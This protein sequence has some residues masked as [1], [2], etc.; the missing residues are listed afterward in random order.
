MVENKISSLL[1]E[2]FRSNQSVEVLVFF[3]KRLDAESISD[4]NKVLEGTHSNLS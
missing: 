1:L 2:E 3:E 4:V